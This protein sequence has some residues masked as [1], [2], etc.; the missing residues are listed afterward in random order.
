ML[1]STSMP[2][3]LFIANATAGF[4]HRG[5]PASEA[6]ASAC[7]QSALVAYES[8][9]LGT[10]LPWHPLHPRAAESRQRDA[11]LD[12]SS[13]TFA[14]PCGREGTVRSNLRR[15]SDPLAS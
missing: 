9:L 11:D 3:N 12:P 4:V 8:L 10:L 7:E 2:Q 14:A 13:E 1:I 5:A 6:A 15:A